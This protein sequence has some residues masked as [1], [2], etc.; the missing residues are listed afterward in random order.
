MQS[1]WLLKETFSPSQVTMSFIQF[2]LLPLSCIH[3][4]LLKL[5]FPNVTQ[6]HEKPH[7]SR[8]KGG[9]LLSRELE[10]QNFP[11]G[12]YECL[13]CGYYTTSGALFFFFLLPRGEKSWVTECCVLTP[14]SK[15]VS[16]KRLPLQ[17]SIS[18]RVHI[19][20]CLNFC[21]IRGVTDAEIWCPNDP[22]RH[23]CIEQH[24]CNIFTSLSVTSSPNECMK[25]HLL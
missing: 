7:S 14:K 22:L 13:L 1:E 3:W 9:K 11:I 5:F 15:P 4:P 2:P 19:K 10:R 18:R 20:T 21:H 6:P 16:E 12:P 25:S 23:F 17:G 8:N 24:C